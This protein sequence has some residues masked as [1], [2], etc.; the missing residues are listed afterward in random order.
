MIYTSIILFF[1]FLVFIASDFDGTRALG[2]LVSIS[3]FVAM[4]TNLVLLP[5]LLLSLEKSIITKNFK[6]SEDY[7]QDDQDIDWKKL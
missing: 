7:F 5:S 4:L 3:L 1:G 6:D 2:S